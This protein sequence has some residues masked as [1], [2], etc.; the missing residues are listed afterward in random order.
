MAKRGFFAEMQH[1]TKLAEQ[2]Q[3]VAVR[4]HQVAVRQVEVAQKAAERARAMAARASETDRKRLEREANAAHV[5]AMQAEVDQRNADLRDRYAEIDGLLT[6]TLSVDDFVDLEQLRVGVQHPPFPREDLREP[7]RTPS[8]IPDPPL[9]VQYVPE[10]PAGLFGKKRKLADAQASA[11]AQYAADYAVWQ[12]ASQELPHRRKWQA[13]QYTEAERIRDEALTREI[14][15]FQQECAEREAD[16]LARNAELDALISGLGYGTIEAVQEYVGIVLA[17]STYPEGLPVTNESTFDPSSAELSLKV[18]V[19]GPVEFPST[20][21]FRYTKASD[22]ITA[23]PLSQKETKDRYA[24]VVSNVALRSLHEVFEA[25]R[26]GLIHGI[27]LEIVTETISPATGRTVHV[28]LAAVAV[29]R[30]QFLELELSEV[31]PS[32]TLDHLG[33]VVSKN[34]YGLVAVDGAGVRKL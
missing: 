25:D 23:S 7:T 14:A 27:S 8:P 1:Q 32:A 22:E 4:Q 20:K 15:R 17:N 9:P 2:R 33:A 29:S 10:A 24:G 13:D 16:A 19:P 21:A 18:I 6:A 12:A 11:D 3:R 26:R 31:T 30:E 34:P 5:A 28:T